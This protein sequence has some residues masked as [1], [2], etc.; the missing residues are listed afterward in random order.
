MYTIWGRPNCVWC[1][2]AKQFLTDVG[3]G[4]EYIELT[5]DNIKE[6]ELL[7]NGAKTVPQIFDP[8]DERV[9]GY[10]ELVASYITE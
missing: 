4:F 1:E 10:D 9:G 3:E 7:T 5:A 6:F 2:R 8:T